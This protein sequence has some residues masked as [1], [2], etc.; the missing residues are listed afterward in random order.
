[1]QIA[2]SHINEKNLLNIM[3]K[4]NF[5][6]YL[7]KAYTEVYPNNVLMKEN[8]IESLFYYLKAFT[9][10]IDQSHQVTSAIYEF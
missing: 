9:K 6:S 10:L 8:H 5:L 4:L 3:F 7:Y 1:M 2:F